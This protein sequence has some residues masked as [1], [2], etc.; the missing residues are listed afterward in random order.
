MSSLRELSRVR[1][2]KD[3]S[4]GARRGRQQMTKTVSAHDEWEFGCS[5]KQMIVLQRQTLSHF[6]DFIDQTVVC[7]WVPV[8]VDSAIRWVSPMQFSM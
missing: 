1:K 2:D 7:I 8:E 3:G 4:L 6:I 5:M